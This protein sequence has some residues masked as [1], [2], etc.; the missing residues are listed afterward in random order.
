VS[1]N[2]QKN[3]TQVAYEIIEAHLLGK[4]SNEISII[5]DRKIPLIDSKP[6]DLK[7]RTCEI[8]DN[9]KF[10]GLQQWKIH[11]DSKKH[12]RT[13]KRLREKGQQNNDDNE[14]QVKDKIISQET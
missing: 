2:G 8:C 4:F 6:D 11:M 13:I 14:S 3:V 7:I 9:R 1:Q 10:I 5:R 12:K